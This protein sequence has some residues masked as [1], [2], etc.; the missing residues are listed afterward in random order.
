MRAATYGNV[1]VPKSYSIRME[2]LT[3]HFHISISGNTFC[4]PALVRISTY[5]NMMHVYSMI[6]KHSLL[7]SICCISVWGH[8]SIS[9]VA[10][11]NTIWHSRVIKIAAKCALIFSRDFFLS[12]TNK[13]I[14]MKRDRER[15]LNYIYV[16][17]YFACIVCWGF[18]FSAKS[19]ITLNLEHTVL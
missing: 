10:Y 14:R 9:I 18:A 7:K 13:I 11:A 8:K 6:N 17:K 16:W 19:E 15:R 2:T 4:S 5:N 1:K 3:V 12:S